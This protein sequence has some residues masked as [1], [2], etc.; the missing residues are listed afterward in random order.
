MMLKNIIYFLTGPLLALSLTFTLTLFSAIDFALASSTTSNTVAIYEAT[1]EACHSLTS[2]DLEG[3]TL[4]SDRLRAGYFPSDKFTEILTSIR[5][6][7]LMNSLTF[8]SA[9]YTKSELALL[10]SSG[11]KNAIKK[12]FP[13]D[14]NSQSSFTSYVV[15][16]NSAGSALAVGSWNLVPIPLISWFAKIGVWAW[17]VS[18]VLDISVLGYFG[19]HTIEDSRQ[20]LS[21]KN[22]LEERC[23]ENASLD[24]VREN[25]DMSTFKESLSTSR[26][27]LLTTNLLLIDQ[28]RNKIGELESRV[29]QGTLPR[30]QADY[31]LEIVNRLLAEGLATQRELSSSANADR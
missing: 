26:Q 25:F 6:E 9:D 1:Y 4:L 18:I 30:D 3:N 20:M 7:S 5:H 15:T 29:S 17:R 21:E 28:L 22:R 24:C 16:A 2:D 12:C 23:G 10:S 13:N 11:Y 19:Y 31:K 27:G 14:P 8:S